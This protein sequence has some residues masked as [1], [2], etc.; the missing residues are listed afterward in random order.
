[1]CSSVVL[2][3]GPSEWKAG[4]RSLGPPHGH[5][6]RVFADSPRPHHPSESTGRTS[7]PRPTRLRARLSLVALR[8]QCLLGSFHR[9][10]VW[11]PEHSPGLCLLRQRWRRGR[12][13][14]I[15]PTVMTRVFLCALHA[16]AARGA[17]FKA[18]SYDLA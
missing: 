7:V 6:H 3:A 17:P 9:V 10:H 1:M 5:F 15:L 8:L 11:S 14:R 2:C 4:T 18:L 12:C 16:R 13:S